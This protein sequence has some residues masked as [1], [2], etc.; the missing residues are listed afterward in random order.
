[1]PVRLFGLLLLLVCAA[2][3]YVLHGLVTVPP[4][5]QPSVMEMAVSTVAVLSGCCGSMAL[6]IGKA[7]FEP[8]VWPPR[9]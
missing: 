5:H 9:E 4:Q 8:Y 7:L 1:M 6:T 2:A 3:F